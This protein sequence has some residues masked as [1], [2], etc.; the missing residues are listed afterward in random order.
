VDEGSEPGGLQPGE[1]RAE[2]AAAADDLDRLALASKFPCGRED[3]DRGDVCLGQ[4]SDGV[5]AGTALDEVDYALE[6]DG[7][8]AGG[9]VP[10]QGTADE[11][12][13][14]ASAGDGAAQ[15]RVAYL[16]DLSGVVAHAADQGRVELPAQWPV[17]REPVQAGGGGGQVLDR[18]V[19]HVR[20]GVGEG[21]ADLGGREVLQGGDLV[22]GGADRGWGKPEPVEF[23]ADPAPAD[24]VELVEN[25]EERVPAGLGQS[26]GFGQGTKEPAVG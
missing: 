5:P 9:Y 13:V 20:H 25:D 18:E 21:V 10:V 19:A 23:G 26:G 24:L 4:K 6:A 22:E 15:L 12:V 7:E 3:F 1:L 8:S 11:F 2:F 14:A 16:E 17:C